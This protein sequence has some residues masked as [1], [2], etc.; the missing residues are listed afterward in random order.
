VAVRLARLAAGR[1]VE[2]EALQQAEL[3]TSGEGLVLGA[4]VRDAR[5]AADVRD[6]ER[7]HD[8]DA[9]AGVELRLRRRLTRE[10]AHAAPLDWAADQIGLAEVAR[11]RRHLEGATVPGPMRLALLE[12][13]AAARDEGVEALGER[14]ERLAAAL[15]QPA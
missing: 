10:H 2:S 13:A 9:L 11:A 12:A 7:T 5:T 6:A 1:A 15:G 3:L 14:A 4:L 8:L